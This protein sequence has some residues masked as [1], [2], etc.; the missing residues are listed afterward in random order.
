MRW[1]QSL[2][3][4][5][6][7]VLEACQPLRTARILVIDGGRTQL[8][9]TT[10]KTPRMLLSQA[11][12]VLGPYD[13]VLV[14]GAVFSLNATLPA[15]ATLTV[16]VRRAVDLTVNGRPIRTM[17]GTV[18]EAL[19]QA[20]FELY[21]SDLVDP[22]A[23]S[24]MV[25]GMA[26]NYTSSRALSVVVDGSRMQVRSSAAS[27]GAAL[28]EAGVPLLGLDKSSPAEDQPLPDSGEV[29]ISRVSEAL[30]LAED[31][32]PYGSKFQDSSQT[33]LGEEKVLQPGLDGLA[34]TRTRIRYEDGKE[35]SRDLE[36]RVVVRNPQDRIV[37]RGTKVVARTVVV[38][39]ATISFW[40][41]MQMYATVYSPCNSG[42]GTAGAC[43]YG[44]ASGLRA[45]KGVVAVDPSL[46]SYLN[47][48]RLYIPGYG[49][50][51]VGDVGGGYIV[52]KQLGISRYKWIDLGFDDNNLQDMTGWITVYFLAPVPAYIPDALK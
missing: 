16:Q 7:L 46:F 43:A 21:A 34:I 44:T 40:R 1:L 26:I 49:F 25:A 51:V 23:E 31:A 3:L 48:Q 5:G 19:A 14:N 17:A 33:S 13:G 9:Q 2:G 20:G 10:A 32:I 12:I 22:P 36:P 11:N 42:T 6:L 37:A 52:E 47:G 39:G 29:K 4:L 41:V 30:L 24:P 35:V 27:V 8:L 38:N 18:G 45:G 50:A 15:S 28:A